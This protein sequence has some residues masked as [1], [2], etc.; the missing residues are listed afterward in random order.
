MLTSSQSDESPTNVLPE[1]LSSLYPVVQIRVPDNLNRD[2]TLKSVGDEDGDGEHYLD[3]LR[4][5]AK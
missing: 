2:V 4:H 5:T 1:D 3:A